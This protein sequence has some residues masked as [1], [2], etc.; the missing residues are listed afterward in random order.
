LLLGPERA[1]ALEPQLGVAKACAR[2]GVRAVAVSSERGGLAAAARVLAAA[3]LAVVPSAADKDTP[4]PL[5]YELGAE[6]VA[7]VA[8]ETG[9][10]SPAA[11]RSIATLSRVRAGLRPTDALVAFVPARARFDALPTLDEREFAHRAVEAGADVVIGNG[12]YA[13][14]PIERYRGGVIAYALGALVVPPLLDLTAREATGIAL[15]VEFEGGRVVRADPLPTTFDD[16]SEPHLGRL[17]GVPEPA[18]GE[19]AR[20]LDAFSS[21][22]AWVT[23]GDGA[24]RALANR[25][26]APASG[27]AP[28]FERD[29]KDWIPWTSR[30]TSPE[31][32]TG[33]FFDGKSYAGVR[34]VRSLGQPRAAVEIDAA[35]GTSFS[36]E[37]PRMTLGAT[38]VVAYALPDDRELSKYRPLFDENV[39]VNVEGGAAFSDSIAFSSG[40]HERNLDTSA[41]AG[42]KGHVTLAVSA[43]A[44]HFPIAFELRVLP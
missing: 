37:L 18:P 13:A 42:A 20:L 36:V 29:V 33:G 14:K 30:G 24:T 5:V 44:S 34:G 26:T 15:R 3:H 9:A 17:D 22:R 27:L 10:A 6:R 16:R 2:A 7:L 12:G 25:R 8:L 1:R 32:F 23:T 35:P 31:P 21:A 38:L 41:L 28:W 19:F 43:P 40:W 39:S 4:A 11:S